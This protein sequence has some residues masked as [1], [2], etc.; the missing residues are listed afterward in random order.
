MRFLNTVLLVMFIGIAGCESREEARRKQVANNLKQL[1]LAL[2]AYHVQ[3][4]RPG[5]ASEPERT[6]MPG[7]QSEFLTVEGAKVHYLVAGPADGR[8]V[9]LLH[10]AS[11]NAETWRQIG[12]LDVLAEAGY[13]A[14]AVDLPRFGK[15]GPMTGLQATWLGKLLDS[16]KLSKPVVVSPSMS[17]SFSLPLVTAEPDRL[18]GFVAVAPVSII[19]YRNQLHEIT[20]SV[21]AVWGEHDELIPQEQAD[22]LVASLANGKK[23]V[24]PGGNHAPYMS[25]PNAWHLV[26]LGFLGEVDSTA[27]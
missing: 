21:L 24:I 11:F 23:V 13:L 6:T 15:S 22:L 2:D 1:Q 19:E 26:L 10:G 12:T 20:C 17:G 18:G 3:Y 5:G 4:E 16:L 25:D 9:V 8:P 27:E 14:Y 7:I